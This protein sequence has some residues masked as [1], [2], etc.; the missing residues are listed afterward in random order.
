M[1]FE[2]EVWEFS[3]MKSIKAHMPS[4]VKIIVLLRNKGKFIQQNV[5]LTNAVKS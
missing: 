4:E 2:P 3:S 5:D 1:V